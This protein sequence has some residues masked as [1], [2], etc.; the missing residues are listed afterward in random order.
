MALLD[1]LFKR[2]PKEKNAVRF[3]QEFERHADLYLAILSEGE[4]GEDF[5][6]L[7]DLLRRRL[8]TCCEG[9]EAKYV[10]KLECNR[11]PLRIVFGCERDPVLTLY[12]EWLSAHYPESLRGKMDFAV[13]P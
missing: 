8:N 2:K 6:W 11:D 9:T 3:W 10:L 1:K 4:E 5:E 12:G 13:E 7:D